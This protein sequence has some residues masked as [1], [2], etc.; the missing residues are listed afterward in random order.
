MDKVC[1]QFHLALQSGSDTVLARMARQY[2]TAM[3][4]RAVDNLRAVY[5]GTRPSPPTF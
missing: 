3:Y 1:P 5:P 4:L 2:N